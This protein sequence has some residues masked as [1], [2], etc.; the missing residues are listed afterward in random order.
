MANDEA[1]GVPPKQAA[2]LEALAKRIEMIDPNS[3]FSLI[4]LGELL[5]TAG[6][7]VSEEI[8]D[9]W[10][11]E[12]CH[13]TEDQ[14]DRALNAHFALGPHRHRLEHMGASGDVVLTLLQ[15]QDEDVDHGVDALQTYDPIS[16]ADLSALM[17]GGEQTIASF[18]SH[19]LLRFDRTAMQELMALKARN[20]MAIF[21]N[22]LTRLI[23]LTLRLEVTALDDEESERIRLDLKTGAEE[24]I[25]LF[26]SLA[27]LP[28]RLTN[29]PEV[30]RA[31]WPPVASAWTQFDQA[32]RKLQFLEDGDGKDLTSI[33]NVMRQL[34]GD[35]RSQVDLSQ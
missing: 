15:G 24:A 9:T 33:R 10:A 20:G 28:H 1:R 4:D 13:L 16:L 23:A 8:V 18:D 3:A 34:T 26:E 6:Q 25:A 11:I 27:L 2:I 17:D 14:R 12:R 7:Q 22:T 30:L 31:S 29:A 5:S 32:M 35:S 19:P 21:Q